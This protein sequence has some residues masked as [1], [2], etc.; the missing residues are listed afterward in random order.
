MLA[1]LLAASLSSASGPLRIG[2]PIAD[3]PFNTDH[4]ALSMQQSLGLG[5]AWLETGNWAIDLFGEVA[6]ASWHPALRWLIEAPLLAAWWFLSSQFPLG[7]GWVHEE[8][9]RAV[10]FENGIRATNGVNDLRPFQATVSVYGVTDAQLA[11]LKARAPRD[12]VRLFAA[13]LEAQGAWATAL[14]RD[15]FFDDRP[16]W[17]DLPGY[18][19]NV[20]NTFIY[21]AGCATGQLKSTIDAANAVESDELRRDFAGPDCTA[22]AYDAERG[23]EPYSARGPH[24]LGN[25]IDRYRDT[26]HLGHKGRLHLTWSM[27]LSL[28]PLLT[29]Q[30]FGVRRMPLP[31]DLGS[32]MFGF[33]YYPTSF[34]HSGDLE[35][36]FSLPFGD[37][38]L[39]Y[40]QYVNG[41]GGWPGLEVGLVRYPFG[42]GFDVSATL[43]GWV[44]PWLFLSEKGLTGGLARVRLAYR[45]LGI[46]EL[47]WEVE[48]KSDGW[49]A[50]VVYLEPALQL[51]AGLGLV[52]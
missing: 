11:N 6:L 25:G 16:A 4:A 19:F 15:W 13:G 50:G 26:A 39:V 33:A 46:A 27:W 24:P 5:R 14:R 12:F 8:W 48:A 51:R 1:L 37:V 43:M 28:V 44:Q 42:P 47:W 49:A 20:A 40:H 10:L 30:V 36:L 22:W 3:H 21:Q 32:W 45:P 2:A 17:R 29:P 31:K 52:L 35:L 9:H 7:T 23:G 38:A 41:H 34:G 18:L